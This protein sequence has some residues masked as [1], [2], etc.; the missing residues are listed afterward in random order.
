MNVCPAILGARAFFVD[1]ACLGAGLGR[2]RGI[3]VGLAIGVARRQTADPRKR[4]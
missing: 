2:G 1:T 3:G 4:T